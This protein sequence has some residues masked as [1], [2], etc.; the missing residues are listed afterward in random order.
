MVLK[1][2]VKDGQ[3]ALGSMGDD[4]PLAVL[5]L[6]PRLLYTYFKQLFAQVTNPPIDPIREKLVMSLATVMGW[7][8]NLLGSTPEHAIMVHSDSPVL[9]QH[10]FDALKSIPGLDHKSATISV[11]W[12]VAEGADGIEEAV[13]R[14]SAEAER[15]VDDSVSLIILSDRGVDHDHLAIPMLLAT[16]AVHHHLTRVGKRMKCSIICESGEARDVHQIACLIG[17]GASAVCPYLAYATVR[18]LLEK[19]EAGRN[20][21]LR[22][23][24]PQLSSCYREG[25]TEDHV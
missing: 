12:N 9:L 13:N 6:Q 21:N 19:G 11:L 3:E 25:L 24:G 17:Y 22:K 4:T 18:E 20:G 16:G 1:P 15:A 14:I 10:E 7:R 8:R 2:M 5:S 23:D